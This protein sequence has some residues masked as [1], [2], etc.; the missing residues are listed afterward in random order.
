[1]EGGS[2]SSPAGTGKTE[3]EAISPIDLE[4]QRLNVLSVGQRAVKHHTGVYRMVIVGQGSAVHRDTKMA[5]DVLVTKVKN[6]GGSLRCAQFSLQCSRY[7]CRA[8]MSWL[9]A[10]STLFQVPSAVSSA[11]LLA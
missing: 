10:I 3:E 9:S 11:R 6:S 4:H 5:L 7:W 2:A 8:C 1:M